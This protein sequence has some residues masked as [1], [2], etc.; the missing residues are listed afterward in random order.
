MIQESWKKQKGKYNE[1]LAIDDTQSYPTERIGA[2]DQ[3]LADQQADADRKASYETAVNSANTLFNQEK[4]EE[5]K[6]KYREAM[7]FDDTQTYPGERIAEIDKILGD[8]AAENERKA[9]Y[10]AAIESANTLF[11]EEKWEEAKAKYREALTFD[12]EQSYP[13]ERIV[14]IDKLIAENAAAEEI[15]E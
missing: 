11:N 4:W 12:S 10:A 8:E 7:T 9:G 15:Y 13:T 14:E 2:I 3:L 5:A 6:E 1:A